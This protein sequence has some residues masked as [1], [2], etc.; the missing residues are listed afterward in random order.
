MRGANACRQTAVYIQHGDVISTP[1]RTLP[2]TRHFG[3]W[4]ARRCEVIH[5]ALPA[6]QVCTWAE[7]ANGEVRLERCAAA[8]G[9]LIVAR[10][11]AHLGKQYDLALFNCEHLANLASTGH[12]SSPQLQRA[13]LVGLGLWFLGSRGG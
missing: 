6:V 3:I 10:A 2:L 8:A 11:R 1:A 9:D 7:F 4:D 12:K 13:V 5:N